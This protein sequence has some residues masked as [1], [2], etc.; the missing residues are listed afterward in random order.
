MATR[1]KVHL[2]PGQAE[3]FSEPLQQRGVGPSL[4]GGRLNGNLQPDAVL[5]DQR[6]APGSG[7][8]VNRNQDA[9]FARS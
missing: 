8:Q 9:G 2:L 6:G 1:H 7:L 4:H 3:A 5:A